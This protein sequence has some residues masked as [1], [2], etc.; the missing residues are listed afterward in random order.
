MCG[1]FSLSLTAPAITE[2]FDLDEVPDWTPRYNI[3]P[4][5]PIPTVTSSSSQADRPDRHF[6][7]LRW[8]LVP[9]WAKDLTIGAK[10]INA[11]AET[12]AEKPSFRSAFKQ[13]RCLILADG[14]YEWKRVSNKKQPYYFQLADGQPFAFAGLW[15]HWQG[16]DATVESCTILTTAANE[17]LQAIHDR[18]PVILPPA[19]Y[20]QWLD[21]KAQLDQLH[22]LL[23]PYDAEAMKTHPVSS[24]V[25]SPSN[26]TP[27]CIN[28]L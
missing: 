7:F 9:S 6:R 16:E 26:D 24:L 25:N 4:T 14:F 3:A 12:V 19:A 27:E 10:L 13:R 23:Q 2:A 18:M 11:R 28:S 22:S 21:P 1:R 5:Q 8:G 15:E 20:D 17:L